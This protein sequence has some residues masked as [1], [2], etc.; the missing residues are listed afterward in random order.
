MP[1]NNRFEIRL[2]LRYGLLAGV[3]ALSVSVIGMVELFGQR[4]LIA[5]VLTLGQVMIFLPAAVMGFI[6]ANKAPQNKSAIAL[7]Y[8]LLSGLISS[9]PLVLLIL[10]EGA[11]DLRQYL[12]NVSPALINLLTFGRG[13]QGI[14]ILVIGS[15]AVG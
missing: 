10:A 13:T 5:G 8:G 15:A 6:V 12:V 4:Q 1:D 11:I 7:L 3:I 2:P 9:I 14:L